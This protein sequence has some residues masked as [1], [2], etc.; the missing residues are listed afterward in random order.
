MAKIPDT[1]QF[2]K[3]VIALRSHMVKCP[4]C[5]WMISDP[6]SDMKCLEGLQRSAQVVKTC[7]AL[8]RM[9]REA[10]ST[11]N[12]YVYACPDPSAH[13]EAWAL[14]VQPLSVTGTQE[15]LF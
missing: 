2:A 10:V 5:R 11:V 1:D 13:G 3:A 15:G 6:T 14:T 7:D 12:E 8:F 4:K 9:K